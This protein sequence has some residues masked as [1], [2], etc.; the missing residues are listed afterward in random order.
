MLS[1]LA[2]VLGLI[3]SD[4]EKTVEDSKGLVQKAVEEGL[5]GSATAAG[6]TIDGLDVSGN[7]T[8]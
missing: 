4:F 3:N 8:V 2:E 7:E 1:W 6:E 5:Q